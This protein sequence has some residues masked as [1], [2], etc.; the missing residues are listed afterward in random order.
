MTEGYNY[1]LVREE[2]QS[3]FKRHSRLFALLGGLIVFVTFITNEVLRDNLKDKVSAV[4]TAR[5]VGTIENNL[6]MVGN[7]VESI[8]RDL[9]SI[10]I[11]VKTDNSAEAK[12]HEDDPISV[13]ISALYGKYELADAMITTLE[14]ISD[15][16]QLPKERV[17]EIKANRKQFD[18][19]RKRLDL[20][21]GQTV[22]KE[23][24]VSEIRDA[25][26]E[27]L[28]P[29][30]QAR[31][32]LSATLYDAEEERKVQEKR[33]TFFKHLSYLLYALGWTIGLAGRLSG[34]GDILGAD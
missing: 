33:Y 32:L 31:S 22:G 20:H 25:E 16:V 9:S 10:A 26:I 13:R 29:L 27:N 21:D 19:A 4:Q 15:Q 14:Q 3:F 8:E 18:E 23:S 17:D 30:V 28:G 2:K 6:L 5:T 24:S 11:V 12:M 1:K 7:D 34:G